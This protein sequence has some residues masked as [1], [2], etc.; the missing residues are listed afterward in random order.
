MRDAKYSRAC[1]RCGA[2][3]S[4]DCRCGPTLS[5]EERAEWSRQQEAARKAT[6]ARWA[7][8]RAAKR[9]ATMNPYRATMI[10][11]G[12]EEADEATQIEAWQYLVT[13]GLAWQL[14]G[15][16]GRQAARMIEEGI[17]HR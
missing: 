10:A 9:A 1:D 16:F 8:K 11:E 6:L 14:Q 13:S 2:R 17:I 3:L 5:E 4:D 15:S 7:R 12:V